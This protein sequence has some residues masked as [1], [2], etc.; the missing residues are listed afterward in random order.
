MRRVFR[1]AATSL[2]LIVLVALG[3][4]LAFA[5]NQTRQIPAEVLRTVP[6]QTETGHIA[7]SLAAGKRI[8]FAV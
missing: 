5:W 4:R 6:F 2:L 8:L 3:A 7:Y 1:K